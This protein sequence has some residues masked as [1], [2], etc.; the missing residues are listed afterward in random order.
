MITMV[1]EFARRF[2]AVVPSIQAFMPPF[3][4]YI[5]GGFIIGRRPRLRR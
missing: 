2:W 5:E 1:V 3:R 4:G